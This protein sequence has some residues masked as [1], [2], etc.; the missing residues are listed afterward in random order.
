M[1]FSFLIRLSLEQLE[2]LLIRV[3][4]EEITKQINMGDVGLD[5]VDERDRSPSPE[6]IYDKEGKRLNTREQRAKEKLNKERT[7][8]V[9][10]AL[11]MDPTFKPPPDYIAASAKKSRKILIPQDKYPEYN[12]IGLIIGPRGNTQKRL[13]KETGCKIAIRGKGSVKEG[14]MNKNNNSEDEPLHVLISADTVANL[15]KGT[16][17]ISELL[18]P[19]DEMHNEH[20][21]AQL[22]E[23]AIINGT[24]R[25]NFWNLR[26]ER[27]F[28][29]ANVKCT[30]CGEYSHPSFDCPLKNKTNAIAPGD[31]QAMDTEYEQ[32]LKDI[33]EEPAAKAAPQQPQQP[34]VPWASLSTSEPTQN[35]PPMVQPQQQV[36]WGVP[37]MNMPQ[38]PF[39]P[40][41]PYPYPQ[42]YP[43][44]A[45]G[46]QIPPGAPPAYPQSFPPQQ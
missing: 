41:A 7:E 14:K 11:A 44:Q 43:P 5:L 38:V 23:L 9:E 3:R 21:K 32:F 39:N 20:K 35:F 34:A 25:D 45:Y 15:D 2:A 6:P 22:R 40:M 37:P 19:K 4:I 46:F 13:E 36:P 30:I 12:F 18:V 33:G 31:Q 29:P 1:I 27:N 16:K 24:L 28:E 26:T 17:A 8:L 42:G 10:L